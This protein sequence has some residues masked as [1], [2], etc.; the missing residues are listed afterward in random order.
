MYYPSPNFKRKL[1]WTR[2]GLPQVWDDLLIRYG[3]G[4][5]NKILGQYANQAAT[6]A[7]DV[8]YEEE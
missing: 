3:L 7:V 8:R 4:K 5:A 1:G 6:W 2:N